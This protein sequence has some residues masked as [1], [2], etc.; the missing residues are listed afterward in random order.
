MM[1]EWLLGSFQLIQRRQPAPCGVNGDGQD[2]FVCLSLRAAPDYRAFSR[3]LLEAK[4][5]N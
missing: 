1:R 3:V 2:K 5:D 4:Q